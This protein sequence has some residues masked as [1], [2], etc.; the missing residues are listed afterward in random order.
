MLGTLLTL[1]TEVVTWQL[2]V[3]LLHHLVFS[4]ML[5]KMQDIHLFIHLEVVHLR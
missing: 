4:L 2:V 1:V 5:V 3:H